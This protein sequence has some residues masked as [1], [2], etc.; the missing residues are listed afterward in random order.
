MMPK[1]SIYRFKKLQSRS[2]ERSGDVMQRHTVAVAR[3]VDR[4]GNSESENLEA[5]DSSRLT[6]R[7]C[8]IL[9]TQR[10]QH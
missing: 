5:E 2:N 6:A 10:V 8:Y 4:H 3:Q 1:I 7:G 9:Y